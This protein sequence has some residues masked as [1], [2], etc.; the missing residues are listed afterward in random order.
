MMIPYKHFFGVAAALI[1]C[2]GTTSSV[3]TATVEANENGDMVL[4]VE[5]TKNVLISKGNE[6]IDIVGEA[7]LARREAAGNTAAIDNNGECDSTLTS[8]VDKI[9]TAATS[10]PQS[11]PSVEYNSHLPHRP[12][13]HASVVCPSWG[14]HI[15]MGR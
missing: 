10:V 7:K 6:T 9:A 5:G 8:V 12:D 11:L 3:H 2:L 13:N 4:E 15:N 1:L 14:A